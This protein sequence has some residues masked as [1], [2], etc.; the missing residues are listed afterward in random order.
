AVC[1]HVGAQRVPMPAPPGPAVTSPAGPAV[2]A[3][4]EVD[5]RDRAGHRTVG[6]R[7]AARDGGDVGQLADRG[8]GCGLDGRKREVTGQRVVVDLAARLRP[9]T[10][11]DLLPEVEGETAVAVAARGRR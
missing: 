4:A 7:Q 1:V 5:R 6:E 2:A 8:D 11:A 3:A 9:G 10:G